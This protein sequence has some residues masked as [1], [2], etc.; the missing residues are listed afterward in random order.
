MWN[1]HFW[2]SKGIKFQNVWEKQ[3]M[4]FIFSTFGSWD[5]TDRLIEN[6]LIFYFSENYTGYFASISPKRP[7]KFY[8]FSAKS[9]LEWNSNSI[10]YICFIY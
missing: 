5:L 2:S 1:L 7:W 9:S 4:S 8:C 3:L 6:V 10:F